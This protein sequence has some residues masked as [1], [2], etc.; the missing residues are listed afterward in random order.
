MRWRLS[1]HSDSDDDDDDD[2]DDYLLSKKI[3]P[4]YTVK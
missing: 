1:Q 3:L 4:H 2:D